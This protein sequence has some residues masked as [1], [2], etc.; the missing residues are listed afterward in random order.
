MFDT[1][2]RRAR[3]APS[4][5]AALPALALFGGGL[6]SLV[7][8]DS[9]LA[10]CLGAGGLALCGF[11]RDRGARIQA[12]LWQKWGGAPTTRRLRWRDNEIGTATDR[13][14]R[15]EQV[16]GTTLPSA[17]EE[18]DDPDEADRRYA[19]AVTALRELTRPRDRFALVFEENM[20][21]GFRRN[22]LGLRPVG[23]V[24]G[25]V[26]LASSLV[27]VLTGDSDGRYLLA[28]LAA[29]IASLGWSLLVTPE[30]VK[31]AADRYADRLMD[32]MALLPKAP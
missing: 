31:T 6:I 30:W 20:D 13:H 25:A 18:S 16:L 10:F 32:A 14:R 19:D 5:L 22:C 4:A 26:V 11:V 8:E 2:A 28:V 12:G 7:E 27:L 1:Y 21:Y 9:A 24:I 3:L 15:L 29:A 17:D 23:I